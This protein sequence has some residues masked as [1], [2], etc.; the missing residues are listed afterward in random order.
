MIKGNTPEL[1]V[2]DVDA[3]ARYYTEELGFD[4][5]ARMPEDASQP[6]E[7]A[8]VASGGAGFMFESTKDVSTKGVAF[9]IEVDDVDATARDLGARGANITEE[10]VDR[11]YGW[12]EVTVHDRDGYKLVFTAPVEAAAKA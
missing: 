1:F 3:A 12:R 11:W 10:P 7:Y 2:S 4:L 9:Y 5:V 6:A 8:R